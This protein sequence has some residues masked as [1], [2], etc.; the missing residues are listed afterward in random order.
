M[1]RKKKSSPPSY[2][3][4]LLVLALLIA[5]LAVYA[6]IRFRPVAVAE[7]FVIDPTPLSQGPTTLSGTLIKDTAAGVDGTYLLLLSD[8]QVVTLDLQDSDELLGMSVTAE[9]SLLL[10]EDSNPFMYIAS[11][12]VN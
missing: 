10:L 5:T 4:P 7:I 3:M 1:P 6:Y 12:T 2:T 9:G 8:N 11:L